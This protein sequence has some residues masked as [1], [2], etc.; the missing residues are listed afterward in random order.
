MDKIKISDQ[1]EYLATRW[2]ILHDTQAQN[3]LRQAAPEVFQGLFLGLV[4]PC[5]NLEVEVLLDVGLLE[6]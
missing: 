4:W 1:M 3:E 2:N 6:P 5:L